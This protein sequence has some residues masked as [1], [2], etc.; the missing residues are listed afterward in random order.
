M[1]ADWRT[2]GCCREKSVRSQ[3]RAHGSLLDRLMNRWHGRLH[4]GRGLYEH[5]ASASFAEDSLSC[6]GCACYIPSPS[7]RR[8]L[9]FRHSPPPELRQNAQLSDIDSPA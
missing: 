2:R 3:G 7:L 6:S 4:S 1:D 9:T 8:R 5:P